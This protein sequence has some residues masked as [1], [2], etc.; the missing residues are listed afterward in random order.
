M[1]RS[2][3]KAGRKTAT[4]GKPGP[5]A[6]PDLVLLLATG[7]T[8]RE[9]AEATGLSMRT[10]FRRLQDEATRRTIRAIRAELI[11]AATGRLAEYTRSAADV[12]RTLLHAEK[13]T[14]QQHAAE[15][16]LSHAVRLGEHADLREEL[17]ELRQVVADLK[18]QREGTHGTGP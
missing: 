3:R 15:A 2:G 18:A 4:P 10:V 8:V 6:K 5:R 1:A 16:I 9:A 13:E 12:L 11:S 17:H 7:A 14:S